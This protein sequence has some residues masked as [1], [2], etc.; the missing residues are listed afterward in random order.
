MNMVTSAFISGNTITVNVETL[1]QG[2]PADLDD[3][4]TITLYAY[5]MITI[6]NTGTS[7]HTGTGLYTYQ[8]TLPAGITPQ[9]AYIEAL[10]KADGKTKVMRIPIVTRFAASL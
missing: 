6:L 3:P 2:T 9:V 8:E 10:G 1:Y 7:T 4:P 5:D